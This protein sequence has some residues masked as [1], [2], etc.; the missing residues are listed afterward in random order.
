MLS[1]ITRR[2]LLMVPTLLGVTLVVF[3]V[4]ALA[5]GG[6]GASLE[7]TGDQTAGEEAKQ[8][9]AYMMRRYGLD[10]PLVVQYGRWLNQVS[11]AGFRTSSEVIDN[12][13]TDPEVRQAMAQA[14]AEAVA[15]V[16]A[17][18]PWLNDGQRGQM[19]EAIRS[20]ASYERVPTDEVAADL[21]AALSDPKGQGVAFFD[22]FD[23]N[24]EDL[25]NAIKPIQDA[26]TDEEARTALVKSLNYEA[27]GLDRVLFTRPAVWPVKSPDLGETIRSERVSD[28]IMQALPITLL[29]N[30]IT[31]PLIYIVAIII[32]IYAARHRGGAFDIASGSLLLGFWSFPRIGAGVLL[33]AMLA[34]KDNLNWFPTGGLNKIEADAMPFL[35]SFDGL[36]SATGFTLHVLICSMVA[37]GVLLFVGLLIGQGPALVRGARPPKGVGWSL[38]AIALMIIIG[39]AEFYLKLLPTE[40]TPERGWLI[41]RIWH[42]VLPV[43]CLIYT[44]FAL[45]SKLMRGSVLDNLSSD[46]VRTARAKGVS[47]R[48]VLFRHV[49]RNSLLPLITVAAAIIPAMIVGSVVVERIFTI[50]GMGYLAVEAAFQKDRELILATT[51]FA[52]LLGLTSELLR[53]LCYA[54]ADPR[55]SYE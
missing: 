44:G 38:L 15:P 36:L 11:P 53:D 45:L 5:P 28:K 8:Q 18:H 34:S 47:E 55:V 27:K 4:M 32:G 46:Y 48:D 25:A 31:F 23:R 33:I 16:V 39:L 29:L 51:L 42:L 17:D 35:P 1:Y 20:I 22:R 41:D 37:V 24:E 43:L 30:L 7:Q 54:I 10:K 2:L 49:F 21:S 19:G 3:F 52:G 40:M 9:K 50:Q 13:S 14:N 6:F 12:A 26:E